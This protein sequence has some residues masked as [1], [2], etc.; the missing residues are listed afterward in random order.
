MTPRIL[1]V[2]LAAAIVAPVVDLALT[3]SPSAEEAAPCRG[4]AWVVREAGQCLLHPVQRWERINDIAGVRLQTCRE[5]L[6]TL[7]DLG[8]YR[9]E[10]Y[11]A[12]EWI[13]ANNAGVP[14]YWRAVLGR[15]FCQDA[16]LRAGQSR[17]DASVR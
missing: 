4:A 17:A 9:D 11:R 12:A 7:N 6:V 8:F 15:D 14:Q 3:P 13:Q 2:V 16:T 1:L 10:A 5:Q